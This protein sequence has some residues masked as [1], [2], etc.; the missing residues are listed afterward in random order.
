MVWF[1]GAVMFQLEVS[2]YQG[3]LN[4]ALMDSP[5]DPLTSKPHVENTAIKVHASILDY[6]KINL[7]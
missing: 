5:E 2:Q 7:I 6:V 3:G 1:S 4:S